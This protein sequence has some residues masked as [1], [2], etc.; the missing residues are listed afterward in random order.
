MSTTSLHPFETA[1]SFLKTWWIALRPFSF[2]ASAMPVIFGT[3]MA[4]A[5]GNADFNLGLFLLSI[6]ALVVI[7]SGSNLL[8]DVVDFKKGVDRTPS[9]AAGAVVRRWLSPR[10]AMAGALLFFGA[11]IIMGLVIACI[12]GWPILLLGVIGVGVGVIYTAGPWPLKHLALGDLAVFLNFGVLCTLGGWMVQTRTFSWTPLVWSVPLSTLVS[13]ILHANNWR[14]RKSD[15]PH[16]IRTMAILLGDRGSAWYYGFLIFSPFLFV[17]A[18]VLVTQFSAAAPNAPWPVLLC[19]LSL[20]LACKLMKTAAARNRA[21]D[22]DAFRAMDAA[23]GQLNLAFGVLCT[24][25][26]L[27]DYFM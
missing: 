20:P 3:V 10:Q 6:A 23:T 15:M 7:H 21:G 4:V 12:A 9:P 13:A 11:G 22:A 8:N 27:L 2:P 14:D 26:L 17:L 25:G 18:L 24:I 1:P 16:G 5:V 19:W